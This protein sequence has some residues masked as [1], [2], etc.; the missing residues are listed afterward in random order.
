MRMWAAVGIANADLPV[1]GQRTLQFEVHTLAA[2]LAAGHRAGGLWAAIHD[3]IYGAVF[4]V[5]AKQRH[6]SS[7][8][9]SA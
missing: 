4:R 6:A 2:N 3:Y 5:D 9:H 1:L 7:C 8:R